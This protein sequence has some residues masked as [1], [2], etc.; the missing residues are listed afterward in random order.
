MQPGG[1]GLGFQMVLGA[2]QAQFAAGLAGQAGGLVQQAAGHAPAAGDTA[3]AQVG[4][5][6]GVTFAAQQGG[7]Q[8]AVVEAAGQ[9]PALRQALRHQV[10]GV[11]IGRQQP[12]RGVG[13]D[14]AQVGAVLLAELGGAFDDDRHG[15][16]C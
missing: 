11:G 1:Q 2:L 15:C 13:V 6:P 3:H 9:Q 16:P 14:A 10:P 4:E 7:A 8:Q 12:G 5:P